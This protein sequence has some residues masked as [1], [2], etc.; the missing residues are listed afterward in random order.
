MATNEGAT[1]V[2]TATAS[3]P[4]QPGTSETFS[5]YKVISVIV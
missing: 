1:D 4:T 3:Q 5:V 2:A